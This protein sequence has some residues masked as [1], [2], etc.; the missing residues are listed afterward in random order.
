MRIIFPISP[1][2]VFTNHLLLISGIHFPPLHFGTR[3]SR[4]LLSKYQNLHGPAALGVLVSTG[5]YY[6]SAKL[7]SC[8]FMPNYRFLQF[9]T[10]KM[11]AH[12][13]RQQLVYH[14]GNS[15][16]AQFQ[17]PSEQ[18]FGDASIR[19]IVQPPDAGYPYPGIRI[20]PNSHLKHA[21]LWRSIKESQ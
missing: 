19:V 6:R 10:L 18:S 1:S 17:S 11:F 3:H 8:A 20:L 12:L 7:L 13:Y 16:V 15:F 21:E 14:S 5:L 2:T 9:R 4:S